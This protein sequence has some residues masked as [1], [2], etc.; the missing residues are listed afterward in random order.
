MIFYNVSFTAYA[1]KNCKAI[2]QIALQLRR[3]AGVVDRGALEKHCGLNGHRGFE[4]HPLR[5]NTAVSVSFQ[6][7]EV[8]GRF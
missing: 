7:L 5:L 4:S 3:G 8:Q 6:P 1:T 2:C